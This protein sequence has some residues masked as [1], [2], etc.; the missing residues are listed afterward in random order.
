MGTEVSHQLPESSVNNVVWNLDSLAAEKLVDRAKPSIPLIFVCDDDH[1][2]ISVLI[3]VLA[4]RGY[5][6]E[7]IYNLFPVLPLLDIKSESILKAPIAGQIALT[8]NNLGK[9]AEAINKV[10]LVADRTAF[11][12]DYQLPANVSRGV[13]NGLEALESIDI[14]GATKMI[15]TAFDQQA[16]ELAGVRNS[17]IIVVTKHDLPLPSRSSLLG[18]Q[19]LKIEERAKL[20][21]T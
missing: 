20:Q 10:P 1:P 2:L 8:A 15:W 13:E 17:G 16:R 3:K 7:N 14:L 12:F 21:G 19:L 6:L 11:I 5:P 18:K 9:L 4:F